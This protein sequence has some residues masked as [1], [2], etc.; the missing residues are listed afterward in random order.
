MHCFNG[1]P[2]EWRLLDR[3]GMRIVLSACLIALAT[4]GAC[5]GT[6]QPDPPNLDIRNVRVV[7]MRTPFVQVLGTAGAAAGGTVRVVNL[8]TMLP[9][10][11]TP[12]AAD[13][14]FE[15]TID[16]S[17]GNTLRLQVRDGARRSDPVDVLAADPLALVEHP[18]GGCLAIAPPFEAV[19][20][21]GSATIALTN[22]CGSPIA[23]S[24]VA[25]RVSGAPF[26]VVT[27]PSSIAAGET[28]SIEVRALGAS[29]GAEEI[30]LVE[31]TAPSV[32]RF[33]LTLINP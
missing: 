22:G 10:V 30:L 13:G 12:V 24:R 21:G 33:A 7:P 3:S 6:P 25:L 27:A 9:P 19:L 11:D 16:G 32:D 14:S 23:L 15:L 1:P 17:T 31:V 29:S 28:V 8:D 26:E 4:S 2:A 18:I 5:T 20:S